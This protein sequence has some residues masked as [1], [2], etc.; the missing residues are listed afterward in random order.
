MPKEKKSDTNTRLETRKRKPLHK[1]SQKFNTF[2]HHLCLFIDIQPRQ[3]NDLVGV[4][5]SDNSCPHFGIRQRHLESV[6]AKH[7][8]T[9]QHTAEQWKAKDSVL[10]VNREAGRRIVDVIVVQ[11]RF[12]W[13]AWWRC[14][15]GFIRRVAVLV[16]LDE[17][18]WFGFGVPRHDFD[19]VQLIFL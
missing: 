19:F 15:I 1:S 8:S 4:H 17:S 7:L 11:V 3:S 6:S 2:T 16:T 13:A 5:P 9:E 10:D 14:A 12:D 18:E